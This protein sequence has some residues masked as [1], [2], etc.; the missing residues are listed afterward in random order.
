MFLRAKICLTV[1][2]IYEIAII[3]LMHFQRTCDAMF[4]T[5]F[6]DDHVFKY[7]MM[8]FAVPAIVL[9]VW[10]WIRTIVH[11]IRRRRSLFYRA[12][13][14]ID[15]VASNVRDSVER[16]ISRADVE[17]YITAAIMAGIKKYTDRYG[18]KMNYDDDEYM[19]DMEMPRAHRTAPRTKKSAPRRRR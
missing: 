5:C 2:T 7:F 11:G 12:R 14:V 16:N 18:K 17:K 4:C 6:C 3:M 15:D 13:G 1:L 10:M 19:D 8:C 9:L